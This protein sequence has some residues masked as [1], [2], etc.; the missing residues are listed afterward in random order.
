MGRCDICGKENG[1][2]EG[3]PN[4]GV[5]NEPGKYVNGGEI[6]CGIC[7]TMNPPGA[8][9]C[10]GCSASLEG[11]VIKEQNVV[12][13][14]NHNPMERKSETEK[15]Q[16]TLREIESE[17]SSE[18]IKCKCGYP[19]RHGVTVC[20]RCKTPVNKETKPEIDPN[21]SVAQWNMVGNQKFRIGLCDKNGAISDAKTY[22]SGDVVL[23]RE[24]LLP[25]DNTLSRKHIHITNE[26]GQWYIE[27]NSSTKQTYIIV[28][29]KT[30]IENG[31]VMVL[32]NKFFRFETE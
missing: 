1:H 27:D 18:S 10:R 30:L 31:D 19:L 5:G 32:G 24:E 28:K 14:P 21:I 6:R 4:S 22:S 13:V 3:C 9:K 23:G 20:P 26:N 11:S 8:K 12:H 17:Y 15:R 16:P 7:Q 29:G 25:G 2:A